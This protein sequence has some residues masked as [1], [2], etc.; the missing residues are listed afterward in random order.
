MGGRHSRNKGLSFERWVADKFRAVF[1]DAKRK[2]EYQKDEC[3][4]VDIENT[5][6]YKIQCKAYKTYAPIMKIFEVEHKGGE[7]P[8]LVTKGDRLEPMAVIPLMKLIRL[9]KEAQDGGEIETI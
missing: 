6:P 9:M 8:I 3:I 2:L 4:G 1:P 7:I 5:G